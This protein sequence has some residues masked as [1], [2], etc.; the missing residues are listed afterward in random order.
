MI[1]VV[2]IC[3]LHLPYIGHY[4]RWLWK[5]SILILIPT[6]TGK[7]YFS[8]FIDMETGLKS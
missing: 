4:T 7:Y 1:I 8:H 6:L 2:T 5:H 3:I